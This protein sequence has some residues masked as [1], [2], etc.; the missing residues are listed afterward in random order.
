MKEQSMP[1]YSGRAGGRK[2]LIVLAGALALLLI[3][4]SVIG[5]F[6]LRYSNEEHLADLKKIK[7]ITSAL[8]SALSA[9]V[10]FKKQVQEWKNILLRGNQPD[11]FERYRKAFGEEETRMRQELDK[12]EQS[13]REAKLNIPLIEQVRKSHEALGV[14][15]RAALQN[16]GNGDPSSQ[17]AVDAQVRGID[18]APTDEMDSIVQQ[19]QREARRLSDQIAAENEG[20]Y[21]VLHRISIAGTVGGVIVMVLFLGLALA[22]RRA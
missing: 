12:L 4:N 14:K 9:Q 20:R 3:G 19:V 6:A 15:Y 18:R 10:Y 1:A 21:R 22:S 17:R 11:E 5:M 2:N 8:E 16:Y 7:Q 13:A